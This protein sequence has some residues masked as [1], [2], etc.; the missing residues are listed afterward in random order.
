MVLEARTSAAITVVSCTRPGNQARGNAG[1]EVAP[2]GHI[3]DDRA[4]KLVRYEGL[5]LIQDIG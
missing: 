3:E 5:G 1:V 2:M 4:A